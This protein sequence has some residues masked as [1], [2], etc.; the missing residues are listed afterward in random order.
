LLPGH[1]H[2]RLILLCIGVIYA[3]LVL[4]QYVTNT[5]ILRNEI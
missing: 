2:Q 4:V 1:K 5:F 3:V